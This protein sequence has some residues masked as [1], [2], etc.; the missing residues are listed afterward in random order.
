MSFYFFF[1]R[2][3]GGVCGLFFLF[4]L[5]FGLDAYGAWFGWHVSSIDYFMLYFFVVP[6][7]LYPIEVVNIRNI[8]CDYGGSCLS[9]V[10]LN[11]VGTQ[12]RGLQ[13]FKI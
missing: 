13:I 1:V 7:W 11:Y 4:Y 8:N 12:R 9:V 2:E 10:E 5:T 6:F 3:C